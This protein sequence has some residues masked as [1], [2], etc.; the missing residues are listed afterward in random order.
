MVFAIPSKANATSDMANVYPINGINLATIVITL[1]KRTVF[2][3][4]ILFI[5]TPV[6]TEKSRNI[7]NKATGIILDMVSLRPKSAF[8]CVEVIP[9]T[10]QKPMIKKPKRTGKILEIEFSFFIK[11]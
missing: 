6:G 2:L 5:K 3:R 11:N 10:S 8:T 7:E 4:P 9:T 1:L